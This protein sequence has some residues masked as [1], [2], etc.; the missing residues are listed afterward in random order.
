MAQLPPS[1]SPQKPKPAA[2]SAAGSAVRPDAEE[3][4]AQKQTRRD[5]VRE[6]IFEADTPAG[7]IFDVGL[8]VF[9]VLS[10]LVVLLDT[11]PDIHERHGT[12]LYVLEWFFTLSFTAEY[13]LRLW[14]INNRLLY[15]R[16]FYGLVDLASILPTYLSLFMPGA[17]SFLVIRILRVM[18]VFRV[19]RLVQFVGEG[20][21]LMTAL[22]NSGRKITVFILSVL[23]MVVVFGS[24]MYV[25]EGPDTGFTSIPKSIYW[26]IVTLT[27]VGYGD[28]TPATPLGQAVASMVMIMG[29]GVIAVPTGIVT[30]ELGE[31]SRARAN[32][33]TCTECAAE[34]H[35]QEASFCFRCSSPLYQRVQADE[36][37]L[38]ALSD[39]P[40]AP[41]KQPTAEPSSQSA[42]ATPDEPPQNG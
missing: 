7:A 25:I 32:T 42:P 40:D 34:G 26:A 36:E 23:A 1:S 31:A 12:L 20:E 9:I 22:V 39:S 13:A 3:V 21:M 8:I 14:S 4:P 28:L 6:I 29:Y 2:D 16:S 37:A 33:R 10:V 38:A 15:A 41:K 11:V 19:L 35:R 5:L 27:T 18:R 30:M 24:L 17:Q